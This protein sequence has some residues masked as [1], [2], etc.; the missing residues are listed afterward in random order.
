[1]ESKTYLSDHRNLAVGSIFFVDGKFTSESESEQA[2]I[3]ATSLFK[4]GHVKLA[5]GPR[6]L[7]VAAADEAAAAASAAEKSALDAEAVRAE[8]DALPKRLRAAAEASKK[9]AAAAVAAVSDFDKK[10]APA[11]KTPAAV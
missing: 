2:A 10:S 9:S 11:A 4:T 8:I 7:L 5:P 1:M 3:E 6:D